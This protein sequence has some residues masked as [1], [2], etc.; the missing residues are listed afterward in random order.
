MSKK[1]VKTLPEWRVSI[2]DFVVWD[3]G[4]GEEEEWI[5]V[6]TATVRAK[7]AKAAIKKVLLTNDDTDRMILCAHEG[8]FRAIVKGPH[9]EFSLLYLGQWE[10]RTIL[11]KLVKFKAVEDVDADWQGQPLERPLEIS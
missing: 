11:T 7:S 4:A 8:D 5:R 6:C 1:N 9:D 10:Y 3:Y 2:D